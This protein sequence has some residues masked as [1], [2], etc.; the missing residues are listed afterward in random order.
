M[1]TA[2]YARTQDIPTERETMQEQIALCMER[3]ENAD[4]EIYKDYGSGADVY[5]PE[6]YRLM[7]DVRDGR[8]QQV[9]VKD[10]ARLSRDIVHLSELMRE[11]GECGCTILAIANGLDTGAMYDDE[12]LRKLI[13]IWD[14]RERM[15]EMQN[16]GRYMFYGENID[17]I[18]DD[19]VVDRYMQMINFLSDARTHDY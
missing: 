11:M 7:K 2:I 17:D 1:K 19:Q 10:V 13:K 15:H 3:T 14:K 5:R 12:S 9:I 16:L 4:V 6:L 18:P 8:V